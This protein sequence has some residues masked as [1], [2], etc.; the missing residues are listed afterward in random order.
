MSERNKAL[1]RRFYDEVFGKKNLNVI[2]ELCAPGIVDHNP[3][4]GQPPGREGMKETMHEYLTAFPDLAVTVHE[5]V[6]EGDIVVVRMTGEA[7]HTGTLLNAAP[8]GKRVRFR[9]LD[10]V[11]IRDGQ[12]TEV[13]HEGNDVEV[14]MQV[15]VQ[16]PAP[17]S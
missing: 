15:G 16:L 9:A 6:A 17:T 3:A 10:M 7:T 8:T 11:R 1:T 5:V 14:L 12:A 4:P 13:W 2:D